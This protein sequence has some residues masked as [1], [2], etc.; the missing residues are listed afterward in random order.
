MLELVDSPVPSTTHPVMSADLQAALG[1]IQRGAKE[2]LEVLKD[3]K[4]KL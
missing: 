1:A 3:K 2:R 4:W